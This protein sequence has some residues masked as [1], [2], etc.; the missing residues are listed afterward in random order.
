MASPQQHRNHLIYAI[1]FVATVTA[2]PQ[3][4]YCLI[5]LFRYIAY[6]Q[7]II[8]KRY[9]IK[10]KIFRE[11]AIIFLK[12][13]NIFIFLSIVSKNIIIFVVEFVMHK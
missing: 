6:Y 11:K 5:P 8:K 13:Q 7:S 1:P 12:W 9:G 2:L 4:S 10:V 3:I